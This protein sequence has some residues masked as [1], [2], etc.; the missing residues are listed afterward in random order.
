[1]YGTYE[2]L[3]RLVVRTVGALLVSQP[4]LKCMRYMTADALLQPDLSSSEVNAMLYGSV[5]GQNGSGYF[6]F[7]PFHDSLVDMERCEVRVFV[8]SLVPESLILTQVELVIQVIVSNGIWQLDGER[9]R[10][11][12]MIHEI[13]KVLNGFAI[14]AVGLLEFFGQR[15]RMFMYNPYVT[16]YELY[17]MVRAI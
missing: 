14:G 11:W 7:T 6:L 2:H 5:G 8:K 13:V 1:M 9:L 17:P 16:G 12:V 10:P 3:D 4:L 15:F